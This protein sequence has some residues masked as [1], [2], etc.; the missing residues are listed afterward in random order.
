MQTRSATAM[1]FLAVAFAVVGLTGLFATYAAPLPFERALA[2]D[3][4]LDAALEAVRG[5]DPKAAIEALRPRL[6]ESA[7]ALLAPGGELAERIARE[8]TAMHTRFAA[9]A[10]ATATRLRWLICLMTVTGALFGIAIQGVGRAR[11]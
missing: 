11:G 8:R 10:D 9:E 4:A 7:D 3:A 1:G 2:R 6:G 5:P